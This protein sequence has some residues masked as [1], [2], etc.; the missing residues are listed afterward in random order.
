MKFIG[1]DALKDSDIH[2]TTDNHVVTL[3]GTVVSEAGRARAV[4]LAKD[5]EGVNRVVDQL[6]VGP[7]PRD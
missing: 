3:T 6:K 2:V 5:V 4:A 7:K 1:E